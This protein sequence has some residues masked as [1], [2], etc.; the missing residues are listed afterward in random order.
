MKGDFTRSTFKPEKR[1]SSVRMQQGRVQLDADWNEQMDI[2]SYRIE[3]E[4]RDIIGP[5]GVP[6]SKEGGGFKIDIKI[7]TA[8]GNENLAISPGSI[9]V[10]GILCENFKDTNITSQEDLPD[11]SLP[12]TEGVYLAYI[13]VW[14]R[15]VTLIED[16]QIR[17]V[18]LGGPDTATRTRTIWQVKLKEVPD[19][20]VIDGKKIDCQVLNSEWDN[21]IEK[22]DD[23]L[24]AFTKQETPTKN[25]CIISPS[26]GY[27]GLENQLYRVEIHEGGELSKATFKWSHDNGSVVFPI[28]EFI[29]DSNNNPTNKLK[30][31]QLGRD[32][33]LSLKAGDWVEVLDDT[34]E[35][36]EKPARPLMQI[37]ENPDVAGRIITLSQ[38]ISGDDFKIHP[39]IRRW[40]QKSDAIPVP[41]S[42]SDSIE[43]ED[44][45][46]VRFS[47][48]RF[49]AGDYWLIPA[50][51]VTGDI[52][53]PRDESNNSL[54]QPPEGIVHHYC[55]LAVLKQDN[56]KK[57]SIIS[58]CRKLFPAVTELTNFFHVCGNG[59]EAM[60][61]EELPESLQ[62]GV[63]N[64]DYPVEDALVKFEIVAGGGT[65][66]AGNPVSNNPLIVK[67][68][69][70]GVAK[71]TWNLG[72]L[73]PTN[74]NV[75]PRQLVEARLLNACH[76]PI[77]IPPIRFNA[78]L[79]VAGQVAYTLPDCAN[80]TNGFPTVK[81]LFIQKI[82]G[83]PP[84]NAAGNVSVKGMLDTFLCNLNAAHLPLESNLCQILNNASVKTVQ[85][86]LNV[87]CKELGGGGCCITV[88]NAEELKNAL[89]GLKDGNTICLLAGEFEIDSFSINDLKN[90][91]IRGCTLASK[92]IADI[93]IVN[94]QNV[95]IE[96]LDISGNISVQGVEDFSLKR[97]KIS[98]VVD[99]VFQV[100]ECPGAVIE[101]N[102][103]VMEGKEGL[104]FG[105]TDDLKIKKNKIKINLSD[106]EIK[107]ISILI[108]E[109]HDVEITGNQIQI[110]G[111]V[112]LIEK[113]TVLGISLEKTDGNISIA[114]NIINA[115]NG[116]SLRIRSD[117]PIIAHENFFGSKFGTL[118]FSSGLS[119][120]VEI[121]SSKHRIIFTDN[122]CDTQSRNFRGEEPINLITIS[123]ANTIFS[124]NHCVFITADTDIIK[125]IKH[126][127]IP[128]GFANVIGNRCEENIENERIISI[129]ARRES[130][131]LLGNITTN[132]IVPVPQLLNLRG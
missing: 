60:P 45:I 49:K 29:T 122:L 120:T 126:V 109:S 74:L 80:P 28:E 112:D 127:S 15:H 6:W 36:I 22:S 98:K 117:G 62:V 54:P 8:S 3:K 92:L 86:A 38:A 31:K 10:D 17:E 63:S 114:N 111:N 55:C 116:P 64:G 110:F 129:N 97:N 70:E 65:L 75:P 106:P 105:R 90:I 103:F 76:N 85:D 4:T 41:S 79:S 26:A 44:G 53:W 5:C 25:P 47:G 94:C 58:D 69:S 100:E 37:T 52:E 83:W 118:D 125:E 128:D 101:S 43:L 72:I 121:V 59:Q 93:K 56:S 73:D 51:T 99:Q 88:S 18:A 68:D 104:V 84:A 27:R 96:N 91:V 130:S 33:T 124:N 87:L 77:K 78:N 81:D 89:E 39:R 2:N 115:I 14:Q 132:R 1:Y 108:K 11:N 113:A 24:A 34:T 21:I 66:S 95:V 35:L 102:V 19:A 12:V 71:C 82:S 13:D 20:L 67:T 107:E 16:P 23:Q 32:K 48:T 46:Y 57:W 7:D 50:R 131:I 123:G 61:G 40:D 9:Y 119:S 30:V 42:S